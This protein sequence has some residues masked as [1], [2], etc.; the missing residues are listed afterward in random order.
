MKRYGRIALALLLIAG[1]IGFVFYFEFYLKDTIDTE[2]VV[3]AANRIEFKEQITAEDLVIQQVRRGSKVENALSANH[4]EALIGKYA[5]ITIEKGTQVYS[6]LIDTYDLVPDESKGEFIAPI[7]NDW[8]FAVP[9]SLRSSYVAD[10]YAVS[11]KDQHQVRQL[12]RD[13][14]EAEGTVTV[15]EPTEQ[16]DVLPAGT[17]PILTD[18]RVAYV[19]DS[20]NKE[21]K[22]S[23]ETNEATGSVSTLEIIADEQMFATLRDYTAEGYKLYVVYKF[24]RSEKND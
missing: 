7:P 10:I 23:E 20:A 18:V 15:V 19:K 6:E 12:I 14:E 11:D 9:G 13:A 5:S 8:I 3:V 4:A 24:E 22:V 21:V 17:L 1:G 16:E 2:S